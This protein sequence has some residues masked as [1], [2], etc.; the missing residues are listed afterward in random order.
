MGNW[1]ELENT[2]KLRADNAWSKHRD[3]PDLLAQDIASWEK[4]LNNSKEYQYQPQAR[5]DALHQFI[6]T[7]KLL[8]HGEVKGKP[9]KDNDAYIAE[10]EKNKALIGTSEP[11]LLGIGGNMQDYHDLLPKTPQLETRKV[12]GTSQYNRHVQG[13]LIED[14]QQGLKHRHEL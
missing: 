2:A 3:S 12:T 9:R 6:H 13:E 4:Q 10:P 11:G 14:P 7:L 1:K 8:S 5:E